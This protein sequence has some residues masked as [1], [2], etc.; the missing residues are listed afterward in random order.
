MTCASWKPVSLQ[1]P[2]PYKPIINLPPLAE[3][4]AMS[5]DE[6]NGWRE[7][8]WKKWYYF[9]RSKWLYKGFSGAQNDDLQE[10]FRAGRDAIFG[11]K[12]YRC[13]HGRKEWHPEID[14]VASWKASKPAWYPAE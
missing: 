2:Q 10:I 11:T 9:M 1:D 4:L 13:F 8:A 6:W 12:R 3:L 5:D 7:K 14:M